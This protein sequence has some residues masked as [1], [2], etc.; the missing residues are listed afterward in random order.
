MSSLQLRP[1]VQ[2][3][4]VSS[5]AAVVSE[6]PVAFMFSAGRSEQDEFTS[7][8]HQNSQRSSLDIYVIKL[9]IHVSVHMRWSSSGMTYDVSREKT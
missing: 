8:I 9:N 1:G 7:L 3:F 6:E 5:A 2:S 4:G